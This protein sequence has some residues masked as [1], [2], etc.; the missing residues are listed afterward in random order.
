[1][2]LFQSPFLRS[3]SPI[4]ICSIYIP[5]DQN[6]STRQFAELIQSFP[7]PVFF[8]GDMNAHSPTWGGTQT[9]ARG[10]I[11]DNFLQACS[12]ILLLNTPNTPT[13]INDTY[14]TSST[15][16]LTFCSTSLA[17]H[18]SWKTHID[19]C[20]SDHYPMGYIYLLIKLIMQ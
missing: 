6:G 19:L 20:D 8:C 4:S 9:N 12:D 18:L 17:T 2:W 13:H 10:N 5:P 7:A 15:I 3:S 11:I 14:Q 1:M 16:D